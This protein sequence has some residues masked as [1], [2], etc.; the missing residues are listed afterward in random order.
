MSKMGRIA[1]Y[2]VNITDSDEEYDSVCRE[3]SEYMNG[4]RT[5]DKLSK[6]SF[7]TYITWIEQGKEQHSNIHEM[8]D[9]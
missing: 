1:D 9:L 6:K 3:V 8:E 2:I 5:K 7:A 4:K